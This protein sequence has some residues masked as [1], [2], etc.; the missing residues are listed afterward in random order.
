MKSRLLLFALLLTAGMATAQNKDS[1][2]IAQIVDEAKNN[3][4]LKPLAHE[5]MDVIGPRLVGSP[6]MKQ[7][8][9]WAIEKYKGGV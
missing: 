9:D 7:A 5:L 2:I 3:S 6:Q 8:H 4:Q 1:I